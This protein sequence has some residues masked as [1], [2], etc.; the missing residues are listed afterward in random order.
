MKNTIVAILLLAVTGIIACNTSDPVNLNNAYGFG[1]S[2]LFN[3]QYGPL[4]QGSCPVGQGM[5]SGGQC[6]PATTCSAAGTV[7]FATSAYFESMTPPTDTH[8]TIFENMMAE[9]FGVCQKNGA[10]GDYNCVNHA[11][12]ADVLIESSGT[13]FYVTVY[14]G[15][16]RIP[17]TFPC[18]YIDAGAGFE[19]RSGQAFRLVVDNGKIGNDKLLVKLLY[20]NV[21][22]LEGNISRLR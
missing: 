7:G 1:N 10:F 16:R 5:T 17:L 14:A 18:T 21:P 3:N 9:L 22:F 20:K 13:V 19:L 15:Y 4:S 2:C 12:A 6:V 11:N 8:K